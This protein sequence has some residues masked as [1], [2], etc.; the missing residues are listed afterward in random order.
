MKLSETVDMMNSSDFR[1]RTKAEYF[2]LK[3]RKENLENML[4]KY[5]EGTLEF[6]PNCS[7][8]LLNAQLMIMESYMEILEERAKIE[9]IDL[10]E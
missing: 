6:T 8:D 5:K 1:E 3:I 9:N 10:G 4:K 7:Y 2:Q